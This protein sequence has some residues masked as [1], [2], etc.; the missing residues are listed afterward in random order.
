MPAQTK[1]RTLTAL[2]KAE[3]QRR[4]LAER[5]EAARAEQAA[6]RDGVAETAALLEA[7]GAALIRPPVRRGE[8]EKPIRRMS[9]LEWLLS[10]GRITPAQAEA[11]ARYGAAYRAVAQVGAIRSI[12][13]D[14]PRGAGPGRTVAQAVA[15]AERHAAAGGRL[16]A[17]RAGPLC[18]Q[19]DLIR[20]CDLVCGEEMTPREAAANGVEA[21]RIE[22]V[23][24]VGLS[25]LARG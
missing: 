12:L 18:G 10:K 6:V 22:A 25:L 7:R 17:M 24:L 4:Q 9:G 20:A 13:D 19:R 2:A 3:R 16:A 21:A 11:G 14:T 8:R 23:V 5:R 1:T 15:Q